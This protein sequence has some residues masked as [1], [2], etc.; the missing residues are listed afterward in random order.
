MLPRL[1]FFFRQAF[2]ALVRS[3]GVTSVAVATIGIALA[4]LAT[5][6]VIVDNLRRVAEE[7][8]RDVEISAYLPKAITRVDGVA[9][10]AKIQGWDDVEQ[11]RFVESEV[12]MEE[13]REVLAEDAVLLEGLPPDLL[14]PSVEVR[15]VPRTWARVEVEA[16][17][18][19]LAELKPI[20]DVRFGQDDIERVNAMLGFA[21]ITALVLGVALCLGTILIVSNT[22]RLT[23]YARRDEIEIMSLVGATNAFVRAP[24]VMEGMIQG[25]LGGTVAA[26]VLVALEGGLRVGLE[27]G[28]SYAYG[29]I[30][31]SFVPLHF[32][33]YLLIAG[34]TLGL[35]GSVLAVGRFLKV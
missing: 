1:S 25:I 21:R 23:V 13:F 9:L 34:V 18:R 16:I 10:A 14:P 3:L 6:V 19:R 26:L 8:G 20:E 11:A 27:R 2:S 28:L 12:A 32:I 4:V 35:V 5:F 29:P 15:L 17:G 31:L 22:I 33:G 7:L 30:D 24:F